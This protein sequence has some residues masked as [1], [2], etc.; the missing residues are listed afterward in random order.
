MPVL[1]R[2]IFCVLNSFLQYLS[3]H[4][5][6]PSLFTPCG[7]SLRWRWRE[8]R[9]CSTRAHCALDP[10][11]RAQQQLHGKGNFVSLQLNSFSASE[12]GVAFYSCYNLCAH[13]KQTHSKLILQQLLFCIPLLLLFYTGVTEIFSACH[14]QVTMVYFVLPSLYVFYFLLPTCSDQDHQCSVESWWWG[15]TSLSCSW[16]LRKSSRFSL[17]INC[18]LWASYSEMKTLKALPLRPGLRPV[19]SHHYCSLWSWQF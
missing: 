12:D 17:L 18:W 7:C 15:W 1:L 16:S 10:L 6:I 11:P 9:H 8:G 19:H 3:S 13:R 2:V 4:T 14:L 5:G